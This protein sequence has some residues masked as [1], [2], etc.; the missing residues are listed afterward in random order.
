MDYEFSFEKLDAW[1]Y[2]RRLVKLVYGL[3]KKL[4]KEETYA[5]GDQ[6][7][8]AIISVPSNIA[9]GSGRISKAEQ[10][11]FYEIAYGSLMET[12]NQLLIAVDLGFLDAAEIDTLKE[13]FHLTSKKINALHHSIKP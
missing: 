10:R 13:P 2:S 3:V 11:H 8:R 4:P 12:Y 5:L 7:R 1:K 9:E 6:I